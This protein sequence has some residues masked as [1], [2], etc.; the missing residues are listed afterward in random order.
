MTNFVLGF[1]ASIAVVANGFALHE[2]SASFHTLCGSHCISLVTSKATAKTSALKQ[3]Q[4]NIAQR[5]EVRSWSKRTQLSANGGMDAYEAQMAAMMAKKY[6]SR[7]PPP[8]TEYASYEP[9]TSSASA[10]KWSGQNSYTQLLQ[11][12]MQLDN[13]LR[14]MQREIRE[15]TV[16]TSAETSDEGVSYSK[17]NEKG[18]IMVDK[19]LQILVQNKKLLM[20]ENN[21]EGTDTSTSSQSTSSQPIQAMNQQ[22]TV[23]QPSSVIEKPSNTDKQ[24]DGKLEENME[25]NFL[26]MLSNEIQY[27]KFL[28]QN[29]YSI[30]DIEVSTLIN[31]FLDNL[32]DSTQK[33]NGKIKGQSR[34]QGK[35]IPKEGRKTVVVVS[36]GYVS[37]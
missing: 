25:D 14:S 11:Q 19:L 8:T 3:Y 1:L 10:T 6:A 18:D 32:E 12:P 35:D 15:A 37:V 34:L 30:T 28:N 13:L 16:T 7:Q 20:M 21:N 17:V 27:K 26:K 9:A 24:N 33:N 2:N 23:V 36:L 31:R 29:P 22:K 4:W 5:A